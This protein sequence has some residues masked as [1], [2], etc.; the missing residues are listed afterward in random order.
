M[1]NCYARRWGAVE[2]RNAPQ[3]GASVRVRDRKHHH[4]W[5]CATLQSLTASEDLDAKR[6]SWTRTET[7]LAAVDHDS[8]G[9]SS[10]GPAHVLLAARVE[11]SATGCQQPFT[12]S[13]QYGSDSA[14]LYGL[15]RGVESHPCCLCSPETGASSLAAVECSV[16]G[17]GGRPALEAAA[18]KESCSHRAS[19]AGRRRSI[20]EL[21]TLTALNRLH[22]HFA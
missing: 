7:S 11:S 18:L 19:D 21:D 12:W 13:L 2:L 8:G 9:P 4:E 5:G 14:R 10:K 20:S 3:A 16:E 22:F 17:L 1:R 15:Q 6:G